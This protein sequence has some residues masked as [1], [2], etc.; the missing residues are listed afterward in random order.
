M[1][2]VP[3]L[4]FKVTPASHIQKK[5]YPPIDWLIPDFIA[6]GDQVL[7][8]GETGLGKSLVLLM[9]CLTVSTGKSFAN[10]SIKPK[11]LETRSNVFLLDAEMPER[12]LAERLQRTHLSEEEKFFL[13][14]LLVYSQV[15]QEYRFDFTDQDSQTYLINFCA[16]FDIDMVVLDNIFSLMSLKSFND[17]EEYIRHLKPILFDLRRLKT[18]GIFVDHLNRSQELYGNIT[19][20]IHFDT[21]IKL[22][23][24]DDGIY[25]FEFKKNRRIGLF[26]KP[27]TFK[28]DAATNVVTYHS[29]DMKGDIETFM[30][31]NFAKY[32]SM[33]EHKGKSAGQL[34][35]TLIEI[36]EKTN[37][38]WQVTDN[39]VKT[40]KH[41]PKRYFA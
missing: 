21:I 31:N 29:T 41:N 14:C 2:A 38:E 39:M 27:I 19:K 30:K 33:P 5:E 18:T 15:D 7:L 17:P 13:D 36:A 32:Q 35:D 6:K 9:M 20:Q 34:I 8:A 4:P 16:M 3:K 28:I 37:D 1:S 25:E 26:D 24:D 23:K 11:T 22:T 40:W 10:F 12:D